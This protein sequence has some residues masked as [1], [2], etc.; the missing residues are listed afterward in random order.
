VK[1]SFIF[2][3]PSKNASDNPLS[4]STVQLPTLSLLPHL[5]KVTAICDPSQEAISHIQSKFNI[6]KAFLKSSELVSQP[7]VDLVLICSPD[8]FHLE[9]VIE[10]C[11]AEK[12][13]LVEKPMVLTNS[14][15][16]QIIEA[17]DR[18][19]VTVSVGYMRR[20]SEAFAIFKRLIREKESGEIKHVIVKDVVGPVSSIISEATGIEFR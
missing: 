12:H 4:T 2:P 20:F 14:G 13:V 10:A 6:P 11:E 16:K 7:D 8:E 3:E 5:F 17:R 15:V 9:N 1:L 18:N 19:G